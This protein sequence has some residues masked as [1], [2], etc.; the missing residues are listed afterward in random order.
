MLVARH[1]K[2]VSME[3]LL[4]EG[5]RMADANVEEGIKLLR[6]HMMRLRNKLER[7]PRLAHRIVNVRGNGYMF[8]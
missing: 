7:H 3:E 5:M 8:I 2:T 1:N 4:S 6:P